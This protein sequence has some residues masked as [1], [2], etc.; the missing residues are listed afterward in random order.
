MWLTIS[1]DS[2]ESDQA[3]L[4]RCTHPWELLKRPGRKRE[5]ESGGKKRVSGTIAVSP[6]SDSSLPSS[7]LHGPL[8][9][10]ATTVTCMNQASIFRCLNS[11][12]LSIL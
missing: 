9:Q 6:V 8:M 3:D 11:T 2:P 4:N 1:D 7:L 10:L 5:R 12:I